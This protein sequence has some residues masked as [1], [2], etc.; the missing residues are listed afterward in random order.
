M[1][2]L[3]LQISSIGAWVLVFIMLIILW[4]TIKGDNDVK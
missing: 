1:I 2:M 4:L 3:P